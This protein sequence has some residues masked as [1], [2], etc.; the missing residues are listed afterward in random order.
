[1]KTFPLKN[2]LWMWTFNSGHPLHLNAE[3]YW[4]RFIL[5]QLMFIWVTN[6]SCY[7]WNQKKTYFPDISQ[8]WYETAWKR[9]GKKLNFFKLVPRQ[10]L[11]VLNPSCSVLAVVDGRNLAASPPHESTWQTNVIVSIKSRVEVS[12]FFASFC[13]HRFLIGF[14][15][16][17]APRWRQSEWA[18]NILV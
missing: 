13:Y 9:T 1:M 18:R 6:R 12:W 2:T 10:P 3:C 15:N 16:E 14:L 8:F 17:L 11:W 5:L 4:I 7:F